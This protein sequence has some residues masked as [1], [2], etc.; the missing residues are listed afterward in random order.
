MLYI[1]RWLIHVLR[2][3]AAAMFYVKCDLDYIT[4]TYDCDLDSPRSFCVS[5]ATISLERPVPGLANLESVLTTIA[6][7][8]SMDA[9]QICHSS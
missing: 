6:T 8:L 9:A 3:A 7:S 1:W 4:S 5:A 2:I